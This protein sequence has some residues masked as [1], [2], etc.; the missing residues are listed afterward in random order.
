MTPEQREKWLIGRTKHG[1]YCNGT[2]SPEHYIWRSMLARCNNPNVGS[3]K[4][5]GAKGVKVSDDW[6]DFSRFVADMGLRPSANHSLDR[7]NCAL[8]Y[9]KDNCRWATRSEQQKNKSTT[10]WYSNGD[11]IGTLVECAAYLGIT[12][13][14]AFERWKNWGS[15]EKD[16]AWHKLPKIK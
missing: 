13:N 6:A 8:D 5:Y 16:K 2:E 9:C 15:F 10:T 3:Y 4:Y 7:I 11:F 14:N 12:K 1:A